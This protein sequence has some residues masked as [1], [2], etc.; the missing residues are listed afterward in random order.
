MI[1]QKGLCIRR[2]I[3]LAIAISIILDAIGSLA[4]KLEKANYIRRCDP[5]CK[6]KNDHSIE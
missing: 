6:K 2:V 4:V 3:E 5:N 1:K